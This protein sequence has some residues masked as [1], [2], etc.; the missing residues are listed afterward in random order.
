MNYLTYSGFLELIF[1]LVLILLLFELFL[2]LF[3]QPC[4]LCFSTLEHKTHGFMRNC[5]M[6]YSNDVVHA[7]QLW[8][9]GKHTMVVLT[10][11]V[12]T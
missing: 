11:A 9:D 7:A 10:L 3:W 5:D 6:S 1:M 8:D 12:N 2:M 4:S